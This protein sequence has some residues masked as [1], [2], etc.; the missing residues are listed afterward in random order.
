MKIKLLTMLLALVFFIAC[1]SVEVPEREAEFY[2]FYSNISF[3]E[4]WDAS[5]K[6]IDDLGLVLGEKS[7]ERGYIYGK[8]RTTH[9]ISTPPMEIF[10]R[11]ENGRIRVGCEPLLVS[12]DIHPSALS[13]EKKKWVEVFFRALDK[14]LNIKP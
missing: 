11:R 4:I 10:M 1:A 2:K 14:K 7:E 3:D 8:R 12:R 9:P 13:K 6:A 5:L